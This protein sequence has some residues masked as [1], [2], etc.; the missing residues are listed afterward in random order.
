MR[1]DLGIDYPAGTPY[2]VR[3]EL[4]PHGDTLTGAAVTYALEGYEGPR[5]PFWVELKRAARK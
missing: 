4:E 2:E 1:V 5:L 3:L